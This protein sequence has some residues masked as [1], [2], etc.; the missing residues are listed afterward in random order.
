MMPL[1]HF[2]ICLC[3]TSTLASCPFQRHEG[4]RKL[5]LETKNVE[6]LATVEVSSDPS[7]QANDDFHTFY[8]AAL[9][10]MMPKTQLIVEAGGSLTL[11]KSD[12]SRYVEQT[13]SDFYTV[14]YAL[15]CLCVY[16]CVSV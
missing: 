9:P 16:G 14:S 3:I 15:V 2:L 8:N 13:I 4:Q 5:V 11:L 1:R 6:S 7:V 10:R 12:G